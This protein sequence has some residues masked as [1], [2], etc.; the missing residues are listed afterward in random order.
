MSC[1]AASWTRDPERPSARA[2]ASNIAGIPVR[3]TADYDF[4]QTQH[5]I[6]VV[7]LLATFTVTISAHDS[8]A[9]R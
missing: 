2:P 5:L 3:K 6:K 4:E 7:A 1:P 9:Y 8:D